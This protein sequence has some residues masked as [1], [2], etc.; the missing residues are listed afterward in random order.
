M[1]R[2]A[3]TNSTT[4]GTTTSVI[5]TP[6]DGSI[7]F[8]SKLGGTCGFTSVKV[9][10][11]DPVSYLDEPHSFA[12]IH[13]NE[14]SSTNIESVSLEFGMEISKN[15][16]DAIESTWG[17]DDYG[18]MLFRTTEERLS[19]VS[20]VEEYYR[21]NPADVTIVSKGDGVAPTPDGDVCSFSVKINFRNASSY[22]RIYCVAPY[23][24][25]G[26][27][28]IFLEEMRESVNS[29][30]AKCRANGGSELS[31]EALEYLST[32]H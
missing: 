8:S 20:S 14:I 30:A 2:Q 11:A 18:V 32:A 12:R 9:Y 17:I 4:S 3:W 25:V 27:E 6:T 21:S 19:L 23:I 15:Q 16:W 13:G 7:A 31:N 24:V 29:L 22:S 28:Y 5:V 26:G 1:F 10:Y